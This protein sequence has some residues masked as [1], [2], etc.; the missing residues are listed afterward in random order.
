MMKNNAKRIVIAGGA[1]FLGQ[2]LARDLVSEGNDVVVLT[3]DAKAFTGKGRAQQW[4][5]KTIDDW[6]KELDGADALVNLTGK[7]VNCRAT[8]ANHREVLSSRIDSVRVL[9]EGLRKCDAP[10]PVWVQA[11]SLA[12][13]GDAGERICDEASLVATGYPADVCL[14]WERVLGNALLANTRWVVL[15][16]GFVMGREGGALPFLENLVKWGLGG[17]VGKGRQWVSWLHVDDMMRLFHRA[18]KED[19]MKGMYHAAVPEAVRNE[20]L[21]KELR[22]VLGRGWSPPAPEWAVKL[23]CRILGSDAQ[24]ALT[25]RRCI[26]GRLLNENFVFNHTVLKTALSDLYSK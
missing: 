23:G 3:R 17:R 7:N 11:S 8:A 6:V 21:M 15:R 19:G 9:G 14:E 13:Y 5:G 22:A 10:P 26:P 4:D 25:G 16:I 1:G 12:I 2:I 24:L 18:L 20:E